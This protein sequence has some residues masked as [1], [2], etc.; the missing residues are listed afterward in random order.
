MKLT[1]WKVVIGTGILAPILLTVVQAIK[2]STNDIN[3]WPGILLMPLTL[4]ISAVVYGIF[5]VIIKSQKSRSYVAVT[6]AILANFIYL[7]GIIIRLT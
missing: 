7:I 1:P 2:P 4:S 6:I 5:A 3:N